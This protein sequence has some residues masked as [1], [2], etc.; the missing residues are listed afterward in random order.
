MGIDLWSGGHHSFSWWINFENSQMSN[1]PMQS[2]INCWFSAKVFE[3][4]Q[5]NCQA[6]RH[7][8]YR[9]EHPHRHELAMRQWLG[10][11]RKNQ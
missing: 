6:T 2:W 1:C 4:N 11:P 7:K 10:F 3:I 9:N 5:E 8:I